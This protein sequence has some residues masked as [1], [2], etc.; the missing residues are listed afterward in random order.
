MRKWLLFLAIIGLIYM[1]SK[2]A[3]RE[4]KRTPF[5]QRFSETISIVV[6]VLVLAYV[7]SFLYWLYTQIFQ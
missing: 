7:L 1:I 6:W 3:R 2:A 4:G 5:Q